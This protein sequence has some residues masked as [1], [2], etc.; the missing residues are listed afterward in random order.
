M[1]DVDDSFLLYQVPWDIKDN[2]GLKYMS[3]TD[4]EGYSKQWV[5]TYFTFRAPS[6]HTF[7]TK[8][9]DLEL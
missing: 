9:M 2:Q 4:H 6:E 5:P 7:A 1:R 8:H 3:T